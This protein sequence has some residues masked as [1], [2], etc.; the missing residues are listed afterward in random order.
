MAG[1]QF[2]KV[3][4]HVTYGTDEEGISNYTSNVPFGLDPGLDALKSG[5]QSILASQNIEEDYIT[6]GARYEFHD[7]AA[8]KVEY[9][10]F[11][12]DNN[13]VNDAGLF[14]VA[15]VTVF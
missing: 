3:L 6:I 9:T 4:V 12:N 7:S 1:Y 10:D 11:S 13:S 8:V 15:L 5:T 2:D 14:R